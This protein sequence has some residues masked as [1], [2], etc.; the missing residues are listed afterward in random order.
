MAKK[1]LIFTLLYNNGDFMLSRNF[2]LQKAGNINWLKSNYNFKRIA[3]SIDE[4]IILDV[5]RNKRNL[6]CFCDHIKLIAEECFIPIAAGGGVV[7]LE[8]ARTILNSGADKIVVNTALLKHPSLIKEL[9]KIYG[10][11]C[12]IASI[13]VIKKEDQLECYIS[14]GM[15]KV[16]QDF[17]NYI[18]YVI[19]L[20]V[21]EVYLNSIDKDG[22]GQGYMVALLEQLDN[23][24]KVPIIIA[25]GAGNWSHLLEGLK[26][27]MSQA[28]ATANL[29][30]FIGEGF[31]NARRRLLENSLDLATW[32]VD[33]V[34]SVND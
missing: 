9:V 18:K 33:K 31:P 6:S 14:N 10:S 15:E 32:S 26:H 12:I 7:S 2:R 17:C 28:V 22:S 25:G 3:F 21:G 13:D 34:V 19:S 29:F 23:S 5:S 1:R 27:N 4:L 11:Q 24:V 8:H 16:N 30:N 20:G